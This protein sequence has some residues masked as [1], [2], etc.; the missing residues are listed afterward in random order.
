M[1]CHPTVDYV[2]EMPKIFACSRV[3][4]NPSLKCVQSGI[5]LRALDIMAARGFLLSNYQSDL[6]QQFIDGEEMAVY[7]SME[8]AD[9]KSA[10]YLQHDD[11][12]EKM[13]RRGRQKVSE[14][15]TLQDRLE[16]ILKMTGVAV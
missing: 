3:N 6:V 16:E 13:I 15:Y 2:T 7:E 11:I 9:V 5:L 1:K 4:L 12:R 10:F 8:D 14:Q